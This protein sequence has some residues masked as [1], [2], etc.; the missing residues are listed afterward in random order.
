MTASVADVTAMT[1]A[2]ERRARLT[3]WIGAGIVVVATLLVFSQLFIDWP[4][5]FWL[6]LVATVVGLALLWRGLNQ[7]HMGMG[8]RGVAAALAFVIVLVIAM[9]FAVVVVLGSLQRPID[10]LTGPHALPP[11]PTLDQYGRLFNIAYWSEGLRNS[12][13]VSTTAA[14]ATTILALLGAYAIA[15]LRFPARRAV[16][17]AVM[18]TYML[19]GIALLVP[20]VAIFRNAGLIDTLHGMVIGHMAIMLPLVTWLLVSAFE[21]VEP[22]LEHAA[23]IDGAGRFQALRR[24][25]IPLTVPS[26]ATT[27]V[28]AFVLSWN[29]LLVSRVLYV[30]STPMLAPSIVNLMDPINRIEPQLSAAG[31]IASVPV[32]FLALVMQR[33]LIRGI[34]E[35]AVI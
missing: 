28:F 30:S 26:I 4:F 2:A 20:L 14:A 3:A 13:I 21:G 32:L 8:A 33:Y 7:L 12:L 34:G 5:P 11:Q 9:P 25:V 16:Y 35:G 24:V 17:T 19:P 10:L 27:A 31:V 15:T 23:R 1:D 18:L 6:W 22:E 29:E